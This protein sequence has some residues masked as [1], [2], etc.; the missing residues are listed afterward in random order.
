MHRLV[1]DSTF[2]DALNDILD[3]VEPILVPLLEADLNNN[4]GM[5]PSE[6]F[7]Q[8]RTWLDERA[9]NVRVQL[10]AD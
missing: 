10:A 8:L 6:K 1:D 3:A 4:L 5:D 7:D 2:V 9:A